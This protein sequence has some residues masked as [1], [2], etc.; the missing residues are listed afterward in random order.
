MQAWLDRVDTVVRGTFEAKEGTPLVA[1]RPIA[2]VLPSQS[3]FNAWVSG[4]R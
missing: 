1:P 4:T 2:K 3:L